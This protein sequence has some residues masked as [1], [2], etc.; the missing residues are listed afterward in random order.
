M[1]TQQEEEAVQV[2]QSILGQLTVSDKF[3][4][5]ARINANANEASVQ[6]ERDEFHDRRARLREKRRQAKAAG[7]DPL[8]VE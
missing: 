8:T 7:L 5:L 6:Y 1:P 2:I 4:A 3:R